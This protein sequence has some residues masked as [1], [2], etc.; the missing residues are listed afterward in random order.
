[1]A[2]AGPTGVDAVVEERTFLGLGAEIAQRGELA[3]RTVDLVAEVAT[4]YAETAAARHAERLE[5]IVTAPG[6]QGRSAGPLVT[7]LA[8]ATAAPVRVLTADEEGR[9]AYDGAVA[10]APGE[11]PEVVGVVDVGGGSTEL[12]LGTPTLGAAWVRSIDLG[13]LRLTHRC[14]RSDPPRGRE[15]S[16]AQDAVRRM[17]GAI[18]P[19][20]PDVALATGGSARA[21]ARVVGR[22]FGGDD[23]AE[24]VRVFASRPSAEAA[25]LFGIGPGR[26]H[27]VLAG[28]LLLSEASRRL[29]RPLELA[30]GGLR[31]GAALALAATDALAA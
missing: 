18:E 12:V 14:L 25:A 3:V 31:E 20:R 21:V 22:T 24:V 28:A 29:G 30:R 19:P 6:R 27:T 4:A 11:L 16:E 23:L 26:A 15:L 17:L 10:R 1:V 9:L 13:S 5:T 8:A 7:A 2:D